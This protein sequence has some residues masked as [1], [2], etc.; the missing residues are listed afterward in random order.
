MRIG[1]DREHAA[2]MMAS[3]DNGRP[4]FE[5]LSVCRRRASEGVDTASPGRRSA[6][7]KSFELATGEAAQEPPDIQRRGHGEDQDER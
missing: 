1:F 5:S 6:G 3:G 7:R 4:E 2:A